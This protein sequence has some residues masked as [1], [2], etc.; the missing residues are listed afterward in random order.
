MSGLVCLKPKWTEGVPLPVSMLFPPISRRTITVDAKPERPKL[1]QGRPKKLKVS[2][3]LALF[4]EAVLLAGLVHAPDITIF[5]KL[6]SFKLSPGHHCCQTKTQKRTQRVRNEESR[7]S[8][9]FVVS[10]F[11]RRT[12]PNLCGSRIVK[13][14]AHLSRRIDAG[15]VYSSLSFQG[16]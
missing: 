13:N 9:R 3:S 11:C 1:V 8:Y 2:V 7:F 16:G 6:F 5:H 15:V 12:L 14:V 10:D 4:V